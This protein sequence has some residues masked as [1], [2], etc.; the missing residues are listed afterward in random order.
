MEITLRPEPFLIKVALINMFS[1]YT[2]VS[3]DLV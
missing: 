1:V 2:S 3:L